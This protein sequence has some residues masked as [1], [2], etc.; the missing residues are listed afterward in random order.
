MGPWVDQGGYGL[1]I[2][3][4]SKYNPD[5]N[6]IN[7]LPGMEWHKIDPSVPLSGTPSR[8]FYLDP[9]F[10]MAWDIFGTGKTVLRGGWGEYRFHDEQNVQANAL[11]ITRG[12]FTYSS[13]TAVTLAQVAALQAAF[14]APG[15]ITVLD[16]KDSEQPETR[17]YSF[18][19]SQRT[20]KNSLFEVSYVGNTSQYLS[21]WNN[22]FGQIN[23]IP[24]GTLFDGK[25]FTSGNNFSP[26]A[27]P[28][29]PYPTYGTIKLTNHKMYSN[30]NSL[31]AS[32]NKQSG[33]I[34][35]MVN[36]TFS[37]ALGIRGEGG[38]PTGD[39]LNLANNYGTLPNDR[40]HIFN[41][42]YVIEMPSPIHSNLVLKGVV[43]G[44]Q[45]SG[46]S[47]VQSGPNMQAVSSTNFTIGG[48]QLP[49]GTVL[50]DGTVLDKSVGMS[51]ALITGTP[52]ISIQ[53][54]LT[55]DPRNGLGKNQ[56]INGSCFALP[57]PGHNGSFIFPYAKGPAYIN[58][59]LSMFKNFNF[60][61]SKKLQFRFSAYN[62]LNHPISSFLPSDPNL[63]LNF[64]AAGL[65]TNTRFGFADSK[66]GHRIIQLAVKFY[67]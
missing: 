45:I 40:T 48:G 4:P 53:P 56:Y 57:S 36:Y 25:A 18:T 37:K 33:R 2:F 14:V 21:N 26:N 8:L 55:C 60:T 58:H 31:Q 35:Y 62:F 6:V 16:R 63:N 54:V 43:N 7:T 59:D 32:W 12:N 17:S 47:Q 11:A 67:F 61:E 52:D 42:A 29:R 30:Y 34:N 49:A 1:A 66:V 19:I 51:S 64:N 46:I 9:R 39:P 3:D 10:G 13:P 22:N 50:P 24:F 38:S 5:P 20:I 27:N 28:Y 41:V 23:D 65:M 15:S 44:W